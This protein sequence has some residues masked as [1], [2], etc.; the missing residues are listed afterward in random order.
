ME[1]TQTFAIFWGFIT[2]GTYLPALTSKSFYTALLR[3]K[4]K[5]HFVI[6]SGL[7]SLTAGAISLSFV[8]DW[9]WSLT[10]V[11]T[12]LGW[13]NVLKGMGRFYEVGSVTKAVK[14][15]TTHNAAVYAYMAVSLIFGLYLLYRGFWG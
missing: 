4:E 10:G 8:H 6:L 1:T 13:I 12:A 5:E 15:V 2:I 14:K 3:V 9:Q 7:I 11:I